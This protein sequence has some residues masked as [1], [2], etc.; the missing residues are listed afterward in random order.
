MNLVDVVNKDHMKES[1]NTLPKF[2]TGDTVTV[3]VQIKEGEKTRVQLF[4]GVC[5][6]ISKKSSINGTFT[7]RKVSGGIGVERIF[8]FHSPVVEKVEIVQK[9]KARRSKLYYL[10]DRSGKGARIAI[11]Y[12]RQ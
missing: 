2:R 11:D 4:E 1:V 5:I 8:P 3:S 12:D 9:G 7:V 6:A 10:K